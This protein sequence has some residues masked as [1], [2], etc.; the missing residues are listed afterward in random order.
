MNRFSPLYRTARQLM[1]FAACMVATATAHAEY[2]GSPI[3]RTAQ[4]GSQPKM[5]VEAT[6]SSGE[7]ATADYQQI[8]LRLNYQY[9][10]DVL[11]FGDLG[12]TE[13]NSESDTSLGFGAYYGIKLPVFD[14]ADTAVKASYHQVDLGG[15]AGKRG[16]L[17]CTPQTPYIGPDG[18]VYYLGGGCSQG[19][20]SKGTAGGIRNIAIELLV[21]G[22]LSNDALS[23]ASWYANGGVQLFNGEAVDD[24]VLGIGGGIVIPLG[25][26]EAYAGV[27]YAD[28]VSFGIGLRYFVQ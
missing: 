17:N 19:A 23:G 16:K 14:G 15:A 11:L 22:E 2:F 1:A 28:E 8:G 7:F 3:G 12:S 25:S 24:T 26:T 13:L 21:S 5:T 10:R 20:G 4:F 6:F 18:Y 9:S 27:E